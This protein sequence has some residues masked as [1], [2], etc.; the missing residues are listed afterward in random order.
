MRAWTGKAVVV[1]LISFSEVV[2]EQRLYD[3]VSMHL[4]GR[5]DQSRR[6]ESNIAIRVNR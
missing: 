3:C 6:N 4:E 1:G 5:V 2:G